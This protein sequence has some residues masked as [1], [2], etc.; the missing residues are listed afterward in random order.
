ML[1]VTSLMLFLLVQYATH[2]E[3]VRGIVGLSRTALGG[4]IL[5]SSWG[6]HEAGQA[7]AQRVLMDLSVTPGFFSLEEQ[8]D[9]LQRGTAQ[10]CAT[11][12]GYI[13]WPLSHVL[14]S[15]KLWYSYVLKGMP[16][17]C[18]IV[19]LLANLQLHDVAAVGY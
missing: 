19:H 8:R 1:L 13:D 9:S 6:R 15:M 16:C 10:L 18:I 12:Q 2:V 14:S 4:K 17:T 5:K 3:A 7:G 11:L